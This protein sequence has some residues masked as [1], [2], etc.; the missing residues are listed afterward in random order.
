MVR[1]GFISEGKS[2]RAILISKNFKKLLKFKFK[3]SFSED[4][5]RYGGG[6]SKIKTHFKPL[7]QSLYKNGVEYIFILVDQDDKYEQRKNRKYK[8]IDCPMVVVDEIKK[9][10]DNKHYLQDNQIFIIM[11]KEMEAWFLADN[12][13]DFD[14]EGIAPEEI[15]SPSDLVSKHLGISSHGKIA[16]KIKDKFSLV[17]AAKNAPSAKRFL[18][19][20]EQI[21]QH[22]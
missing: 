18:N 20:L 9:Y 13:L 22:Q 19:K 10:R 2:D 12:E 3:I 16:H 21:S 11:T 4:D 7:V 14:C 17:R 15:L 5:I 8:P 1:V 6:K